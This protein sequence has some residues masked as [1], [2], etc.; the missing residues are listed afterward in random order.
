MEY[1][2]LDYIRAHQYLYY[3]LGLP[4][5]SDH[6]YDQW[7]RNN[8]KEDYKNGSDLESSYTTEQ[9][10]LANLIFTGKIKPFPNNP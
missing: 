7:G 8:C 10:Q 1:S 4:V 2:N 9:K 6:E 5:I 3:C